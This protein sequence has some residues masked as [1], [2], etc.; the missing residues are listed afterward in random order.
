[1]GKEQH[2]NE[3]PESNSVFAEKRRL[4]SS[5]QNEEDNTMV[6]EIRRIKENDLNRKDM[7]NTEL[8]GD[9][10]TQMFP[11]SIMST[12]YVGIQISGLVSRD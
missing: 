4:I 6:N 2:E 10:I 11:C 1:M 7:K 3:N 5:A 9:S 12:S 8:R